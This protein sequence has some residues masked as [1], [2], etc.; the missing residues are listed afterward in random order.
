[1]KKCPQFSI[2]IP[3]FNRSSELLAAINSIEK[4]TADD[5]ECI[6]VDDGSTD[7]TAE[8][9][10]RCQ[11]RN[12][13]I[14][15]IR[16]NHG[17]ASAAR[18]SGIERSSGKIICFLDSDDLYEKHTLSL[19]AQAFEKISGQYICLRALHGRAH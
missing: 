17:G 5:W 19:F 6:V 7:N 11:S 2:V 16:I 4:Q 9:V 12:N 18:N 14:K 13:R 15:Y 3:T 8:L 10:T 1:M